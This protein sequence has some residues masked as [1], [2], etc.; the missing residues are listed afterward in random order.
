MGG[1][2]GT[3]LGAACILGSVDDIIVGLRIFY[4]I[5]GLRNF[6]QMERIFM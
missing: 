6:Y 3:C 4:I 2:V 1:Y 5:V